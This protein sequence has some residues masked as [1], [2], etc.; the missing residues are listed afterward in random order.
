MWKGAAQRCPSPLQVPLPSFT[1]SSTS[2]VRN[3]YKVM[4]QLGGCWVASVHQSALHQ[5]DVMLACHC[6][7][8]LSYIA[9]SARPDVHQGLQFK[10]ALHSLYPVILQSHRGQMK[11]TPLG[12][13]GVQNVRNS[14][15]QGM[16]AQRA[17]LKVVMRLSPWPPCARLTPLLN[18]GYV[19]GM[20]SGS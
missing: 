6:A 16:K 19:D 9:A 7:A 11:H 20:C 5:L 15:S 18:L 10:S 1:A 3:T 17:G 4:A 2:Y 14:L 8:S 12:H 13:C